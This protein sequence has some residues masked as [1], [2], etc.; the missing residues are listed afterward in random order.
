MVKGWDGVMGG[1]KFESQCGQKKEE[2]KYLHIQILTHN[3]QL[4]KIKPVLGVNM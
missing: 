3:N 1:S 2:K 4:D